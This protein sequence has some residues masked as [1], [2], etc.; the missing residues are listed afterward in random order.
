MDLV[1]QTGET[2]TVEPMTLS[3]DRP[4]PWKGKTVH[5]P[6]RHPADPW[7]W[8]FYDY[9]LTSDESGIPLAQVKESGKRF[10][11]QWDALASLLEYV[12]TNEGE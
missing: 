3:G 10:G 12:G 9:R 1:V 6:H 4:V 8:T 7:L 11:T 5:D 2:S